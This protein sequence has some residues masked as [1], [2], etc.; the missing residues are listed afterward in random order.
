MEEGDVEDERIWGPSRDKRKEPYFFIYFFLFL[1]FFEGN[2]LPP[3]YDLNV[4][5]DCGP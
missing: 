1:N 2:F 4:L 3:G 5:D